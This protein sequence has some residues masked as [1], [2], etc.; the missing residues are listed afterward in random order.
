GF[1]GG[2]GAGKTTTMRIA[3]GL[4]SKEAG[5]ISLD[6]TELTADRRRGF[7]YMPE[8]RGLYPKMKVLEQI[9]YLA[10]LHGFDKREATAK[11]TA[12]L[13]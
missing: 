1:V 13:T 11:A 2:N 5:S 4:L 9:A 8:E 12:I 3:L 7:G 6:G 10:R